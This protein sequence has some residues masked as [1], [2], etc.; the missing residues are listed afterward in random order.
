MEMKTEAEE[1]NF[2]PMANIHNIVEIG[3]G[4]QTLRATQKESHSPN[5][6]MTTSR[7]I[8]DTEEIFKA[9]CSNLD[10]DGAAAF[11]V[12]ENSAVP[13]ALSG[14]DF[15][16]GQTLVLN[17]HRIKRIDCHPAESYEGGSPRSISGAENWLNWN[18]DLDNTNDREHAWEAGNESHMEL[19]NGCE[20]SEI[21]RALE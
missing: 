4:S 6:Q 19:D 10:H 11:I 3:Q 21:P 15:P 2:H 7:Y 16:G 18:G 12:S 1:K 17:V 9:L 8:S 13:P 14:K 5:N 20:D